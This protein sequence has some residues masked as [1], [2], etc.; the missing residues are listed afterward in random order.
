[1][2][3]VSRVLKRWLPVDPDYA[4]FG[5]RLLRGLNAFPFALYLPI[6]L[7]RSVAD[8]KHGVAF[9][10]ATPLG[11]VL[12][13]SLWRVP[14]RLVLLFMLVTYLMMAAVAVLNAS[15]RLS[16][17]WRIASLVA[18]LAVTAL[19]VLPFNLELYKFFGAMRTQRTTLL[20]PLNASIVLD[21]L[22]F[23]ALATA[24]IYLRRRRQ[25]ALRALRSAKL[26]RVNVERQETERRLQSLQAQ[27]EPH[28]LFNTLAH[29]LRLHQ[30]DAKRGRE[31]LRSLTEY[32]AS[33]L[34]QVRA[35]NFTL[36]R[37]LALTRAYVNVQQIRMGER[38]RV[39]I[40]V[41]PE[42]MHARM[43]AMTVL[44]LAENAVKH[45]LGPKSEGGTLRIEASLKG[46]LLEVAVCDDGVGLQLGAGTGHGLANTRS[47]LIAAYGQR[48]ALSIANGEGGGVRAALAVPYA[49]VLAGARP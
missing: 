4:P 46:E 9:R 32:M 15:E 43:P 11:V 38:L 44:T 37:E 22:L 48:A 39:T 21:W 19:L 42:L 3:R 35:P 12:L 25:D 28:F 41:P 45:G 2:M 8:L 34:P 14:L 40:D 29:I 1:M 27:I 47:R 24:P 18:A 10:G 20:H 5:W 36:G 26:Q 16:N 13:D 6:A 23:G 30:V 17:R 31:M 49:P 7:T 33:A